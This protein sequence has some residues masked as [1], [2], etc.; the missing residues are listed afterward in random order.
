MCTTV[1]PFN[2]I[3]INFNHLVIKDDDFQS[4]ASNIFAQSRL[5]QDFS[6]STVHC[7]CCL[8][9]LFMMGHTFSIVDRSVISTCVY[10]TAHAEWDLALSWSNAHGFP[11][12]KSSWWQY[13]SLYNPNI[14]LHV[15]GTF[16]HMQ[17]THAV[18]T[19]APSNHNRRFLLHLLLIDVW[20]VHFVFGTD[21]LINFSQ[22]LAEI[23]THL[24]TAHIS[25]VFWTV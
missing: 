18:W 9:L 13:M 23:W 17:V 16:T 22:K 3:L 12:K 15:S 11:W 4:F 25:T 24:T 5:I 1:F 14:C 10:K 19:D 21:N 8:I 2:Y 7:L 20:M 6:C